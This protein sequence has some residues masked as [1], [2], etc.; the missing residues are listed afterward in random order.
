MNA[1]RHTILVLSTVVAAA[2]A[3]VAVA[4]V[5]VPVRLLDRTTLLSV[6]SVPRIVFLLELVSA[7]ANKAVFFF[8]CNFN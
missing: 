6:N 8:K 3:A 5:A 7:A 4:A 1:V 2:V